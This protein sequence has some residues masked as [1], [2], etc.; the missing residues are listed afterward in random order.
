[1]QQSQ[2]EQTRAATADASA[3]ARAGLQTK[4]KRSKRVNGV[5]VKKCADGRR[6]PEKF[7]KTLKPFFGFSYCIHVG[8]AANGV[9]INSSGLLGLR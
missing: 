6:M 1:M 3:L 9:S 5:S 7:G 2:E 8:D 4:K